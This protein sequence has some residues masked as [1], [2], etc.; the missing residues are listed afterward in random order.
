MLSVEPSADFD[1]TIEVNAGRSRPSL[2][3]STVRNEMQEVQKRDSWN[4]LA[5]MILVMVILGVLFS[6]TGCTVS[7]GVEGRAFYPKNDPRKGFFDLGGLDGIFSSGGGG[8]GGFA[9]LG[10]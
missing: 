7:A 2:G 6:A 8:G 1:D 4:L 5:T 9:T 10:D 3:V